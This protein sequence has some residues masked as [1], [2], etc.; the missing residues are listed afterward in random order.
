MRRKLLGILFILIGI[1]A[2]E[3]AYA[4]AVELYCTT[5]VS[6]ANLVSYWRFYD[7]ST[8]LNDT[9]G[10]NTLTNHSAVSTTTGEFNGAVDYG[11]SNNSHYL[12]LPSGLSDGGLN[13]ATHDW[14]MN[15]WVYL[16]SFPSNNANYE[17]VDWRNGGYILWSAYNNGGTMG[18]N[19]NCN[20]TANFS[21]T[22]AATGTW[23]MYTITF[24]S[25]TGIATNYFNGVF[26][27]TSSCTNSSQGNT[28]TVGTPQSLNAYMS[29]KM[30]DLS[31]FKET[32][33]ST[34]VSQLY[35][36]TLP[37]SGNCGS[38][39]VPPEK[40]WWWL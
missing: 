27:S 31:F 23:Q 14:S 4:S 5:L 32:L 13:P 35:N 39:A 7:S 24:S 38:T 36:G 1:L 26:N 33:S 20:S 2:A 18:I 16:Y 30:D 17:I 28:F 40:F 6:D 11:T 34:T 3:I 29:G 21:A 10:S 9:I 15:A 8:W 37:S 25:A 12:N 19:A 22:G